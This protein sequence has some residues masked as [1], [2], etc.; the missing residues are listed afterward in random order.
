M[1]VRPPLAALRHAGVSLRRATNDTVAAK[2]AASFVAITPRAAARDFAQE[3]VKLLSFPGFLRH[4]ILPVR[5]ADG[6]VARSDGGASPLRP[7]AP[8]WAGAPALPL[9]PLRGQLALRAVCDSPMPAEQGGA[10][11]RQCEVAQFSWV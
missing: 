10:W 11:A 2:P 3:C 9:R 1:P 8:E 5:E 6:E 4:Q 7:T